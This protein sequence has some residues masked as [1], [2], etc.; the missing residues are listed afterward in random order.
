[1]K[2]FLCLLLCVLCIPF[3]SCS[4][5]ND[6]PLLLYADEPLYLGEEDD[7]AFEY[8]YYE[9][10]GSEIKRLSDVSG[11]G[12]LKSYCDSNGKNYDGEVKYIAEVLGK[13][14]AAEK[15][16]FSSV[17]KSDGFGF[18]FDG[19]PYVLMY[20]GMSKTHVIYY[21]GVCRA[22]TDDAFISYI[23]EVVGYVN[24]ILFDCNNERKGEMSYYDDNRHDKYDMR[25]YYDLHFYDRHESGFYISYEEESGDKRVKTKDEIAY[26]A[27]SKFE[28]CFNSVMLY[29]DEEAGMWLAFLS[30]RGALDGECDVYIDIYGNIKGAEFTWCPGLADGYPPLDFIS[31]RLLAEYGAY[32]VRSDVIGIVDNVYFRVESSAEYEDGTY[33]TIVSIVSGEKILSSKLLDE[34]DVR[35]GY[36]AMFEEV[37]REAGI[38][39]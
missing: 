1:M 29:K 12:S 35:Q 31:Q 18:E 37:E 17:V 2:R 7:V 6:V 16:A 9:Y 38:K 19:E 20:D 30:V 5:K 32:Y 23:K 28:G 26:I 24:L 3:C 25:F 10:N 21:N 36:D 14:A 15:L 33:K 27:Q 13:S 22:F 4:F 39:N 11:A 34:D 8:A